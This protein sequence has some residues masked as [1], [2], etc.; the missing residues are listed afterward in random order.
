MKRSISEVCWTV[1]CKKDSR[2]QNLEEAINDFYNE[3]TY[4]T[5]ERAAEYA[6]ELNDYEDEEYFVPA[7]L[8]ITLT[9]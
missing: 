4:K 9:R 1:V 8:T 6:R 3:N 2:E 7:K 5:E